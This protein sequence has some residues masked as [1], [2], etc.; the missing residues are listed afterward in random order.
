[1]PRAQPSTMG[2][3][4]ANISP[5]ALSTIDDGREPTLRSAATSGRRNGHQSSG[6]VVVSRTRL[7]WVRAWEP[8][9][10]RIPH[11]APRESVPPMPGFHR[12]IAGASGTETGLEL[13]PRQPSHA[14]SADSSW[15]RIPVSTTGL[16][17]SRWRAACPEA[18]DPS[19]RPCHGKQASGRNGAGLMVVVQLESAS[20]GGGVASFS[21]EAGARS[22]SVAARERAVTAILQLDVERKCP[23][24]SRVNRRVQ[25]PRLRCRHGPPRG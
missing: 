4:P 3:R 6:P 14:T 5:P 21:R 24:G 8:Q 10:C 13:I 12:E 19:R 16:V 25:S 18:N 1:M 22:R 7:R 2:A 20:A 15:Q 11:R 9:R 23:G 17:R